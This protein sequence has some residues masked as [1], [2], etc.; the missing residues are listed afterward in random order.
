MCRF[1]YM[2]YKLEILDH[3]ARE[4]QGLIGPS[5][6]APIPVV[7]SKD[8]AL[9]VLYL[10]PFCLLVLWHH[11]PQLFTYCILITFWWARL[12]LVLALD[13]LC[14]NLIVCKVKVTWCELFSRSSKISL[15]GLL[16]LE[17]YMIIGMKRLVSRFFSMCS[18]NEGRVVCPYI[19]VWIEVLVLLLLIMLDKVICFFRLNLNN[20]FFIVSDNEKVIVCNLTGPLC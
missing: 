15:T 10:L 6:G 4:R 2:L 20:L 5:L 7:L 14:F 1:E 13:R 16:W 18:D 17:V 9:E 3:K 12:A 19:H 8:N 11:L